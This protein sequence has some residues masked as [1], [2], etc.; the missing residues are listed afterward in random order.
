MFNPFSRTRT[1]GFNVRPQDDVPRFRLD[2]EVLD[3]EAE[4]PGFNFRGRPDYFD[5]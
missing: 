4:V 1:P 5:R 3:L 2:P